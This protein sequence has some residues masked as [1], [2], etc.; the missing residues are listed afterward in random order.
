MQYKQ[1]GKSGLR[2]SG[3]CLGMMSYG[4]SKWA[5][6]VLDKSAGAAFVMQALEHGINFFDT[7]DFYSYGAS[8][9]V[10][11]EAINSVGRRHE[12]VIS[13]KVGLPMDQST[14]G[15]GLS[16]KHIHESVNASLRRLKTDYIDLYT[17]HV[18]DSA[19]P[20][21]ETVDALND[22][23]GAGKIL[24]YGASNYMTWQLAHAHYTALS[25][26][27]RGF[28]S[29]QLQYNL[30]YREEERDMLPFCD[31]EGLGVMVYSPLARGWLV[32][33]DGSASELTDREKTRATQDAK[34]KTL[35]G[36]NP[37]HAVRNRLLEIAGARGLPPGRIAL[38]WLHSRPGV[39]SVIVGALETS[40][41]DEAV[42]S[43]EVRLTNEEI[44]L[45]EE[46]YTPVSIKSDGLAAVLKQQKAR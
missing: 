26:S 46:A 37:D 29:M 14:N 15:R 41:L 33:G 1:L 25:R 38:A 10:L 13:T 30:L 28:T 2:V 23:V 19:T 12:T 32:S 27:G 17:L 4:S 44:A 6:W 45:L 36:S 40:H 16:R 39:S 43:L 9:E 42:A 31:L 24:Y 7:A 35:Y 11:G 8:E 20:I 22:L 5:P 34:T 21:E 3:L 18:P